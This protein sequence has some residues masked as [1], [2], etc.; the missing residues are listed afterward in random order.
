MRQKT[1]LWGRLGKITKSPG[2]RC[3]QCAKKRRLSEPENKVIAEH[4]FYFQSMKKILDDL[5]KKK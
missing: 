3:V 5:E 1:K 2:T 4:Q